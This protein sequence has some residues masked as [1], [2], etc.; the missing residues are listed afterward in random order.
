MNDKLNV[1]VGDKVIYHPS[2]SCARKSIATISKITPT[3]RIKISGSMTQYD[4][5]GREMGNTRAWSSTRISEAT[6]ELIQEIEQQIVIDNCL[7]RISSIKEITYDQA[8]EI[9]NILK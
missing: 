8:V 4:A 6:E 9:L 5:T 1:K 3:G 7:R 2:G